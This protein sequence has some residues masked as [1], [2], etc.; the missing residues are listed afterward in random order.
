MV[1]ATMKADGQVYTPYSCKA[2]EIKTDGAAET[3]IEHIVAL[4]PR[5]ENGTAA[6]AQPRA[7]PPRCRRHRL[8]AAR[9]ALRNRRWRDGWHRAPCPRPG[10]DL[11]PGIGCR[12][13]PDTPRRRSDRGESIC[14]SAVAKRNTKRQRSRTHAE[15][16][17]AAWRRRGAD[18]TV[19]AA[20]CAANSS[21]WPATIRHIRHRHPTMGA[22][23]TAARGSPSAA[24]GHRVLPEEQLVDGGAAEWSASL[25]AA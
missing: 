13:A 6:R 3:E 5:Y 25:P 7:V 16:R 19:R 20:R 12:N 22:A 11:Q 8:R 9:P 24:T 14:R 10:S 2:F 17:H 4:G 23:D 15:R 1:P 21:R 18:A